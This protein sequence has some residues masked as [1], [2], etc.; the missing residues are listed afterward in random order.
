MEINQNK[1]G[2]TLTAALTGRLDTNTA[3]KLQEALFGAIDGSVK[4]LEIDLADLDY[5]SSA[6]LRVLLALQK[7]CTA[8][9][10]SMFLSHCNDM[11]R[12]VFRMTGFDK[13]LDIR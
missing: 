12:D 4:T 2:E 11:T 8:H 3:P 5:I 13:I 7:L 9:G 6:G 10:A 1:T